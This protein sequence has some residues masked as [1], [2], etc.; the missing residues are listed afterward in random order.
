V[1]GRVLFHVQHLLGVGHL[2]RAEIIARALTAEGLDVTVAFG[3][4]PTSEVGFA[5]L[6]VAMLPAATIANDDFSRLLDAKGHAVD[7]AWKAARRGALLELYRAF[8]PDVVLV[9]LFPFG[10]RQFAFELVPLLE[11]LHSTALR[12][13]VACSVRDILVESKRP[14]RDKEIVETVRRWFDAV[15]VHGDP[16]LIPFFETFPAADSI[17]D[18]IRYTGYVADDT[19]AATPQAGHGEVLVSAGGG[20]VGLPLLR[21][22]L[23]ARPLTALAGSVWRFLTGPNL[24][25]KDFAEL[26]VATDDRTIIERFRPDFPLRLRVAA[27]SISQGGYNTTMDILRAGVPAVVVPYETAS[28]TEQRLRAEL[29]AAKGLLTIIPA[30]ELSP[31]RLAKAVEAA[32]AKSAAPPVKVDLDGA[33]TTARF[34]RDLA[35]QRD[36]RRRD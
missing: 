36:L 34:V 3:G 10:R 14:A 2:K 8:D 22:A 18:L 6:H 9:E 23:A 24:P 29:F 25:D 28:E 21:A 11:A 7:D 19:E 4:R 32:L 33:A 20:A 17:A 26:S 35:A 12:P 31:E 15:L 5:G 13:R 30:S 16:A 27:L 1:S